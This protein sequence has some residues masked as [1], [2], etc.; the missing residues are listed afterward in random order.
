MEST[1]SVMVDWFEGGEQAIDPLA[2]NAPQVNRCAV[3]LTQGDLRKIGLRE[4]GG[5][6]AIRKHG[7]LDEPA[8]RQDANVSR[9]LRH[10]PLTR[11]SLSD[12]YVYVFENMDHTRPQ[13]R[14]RVVVKHVGTGTVCSN[15]HRLLGWIEQGHPQAL[16]QKRGR[17]KTCK[18]S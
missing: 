5:K 7:Y 3:A 12:Y 10:M 11:V 1:Q 14:A 16:L 6:Y 17:K 8:L 18:N 4:S 9:V 15:K 13:T 2:E